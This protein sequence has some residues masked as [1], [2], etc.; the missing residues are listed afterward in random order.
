MAVPKRPRYDTDVWSSIRTKTETENRR[1]NAEEKLVGVNYLCPKRNR[2]VCFRKKKTRAPR[3]DT[4]PLTPA[5]CVSYLCGTTFGAHTHT[6]AI[7]R[8]SARRA[9]ETTGPDCY[10]TAG[11]VIIMTFRR[12]PPAAI[13]DRRRRPSV[14]VRARISG[15]RWRENNRNQKSKKKKIFL[16]ICRVLAPNGRGAM[17]GEV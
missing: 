8:Q 6:R 17:T 11:R 14:C 15:G 4:A 5:R 10:R 1:R 13:A 16:F 9:D 2:I 7:R 12:A 3:I